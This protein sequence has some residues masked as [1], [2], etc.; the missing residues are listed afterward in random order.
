MRTI[1]GNI[2]SNLET[3]AKAYTDDKLKIARDNAGKLCDG[4]ID[5]CQNIVNAWVRAYTGGQIT[6]EILLENIKDSMINYEKNFNNAKQ[7]WCQQ[8][9]T[10]R[11]ELAKVS[12]APFILSTIHSAKGLEFD[13]VVVVINDDKTM[14]EE[15]KR[16]YYVALT[17]A[18]KSE[19]IIGHTK[20]TLPHIEIAYNS[21]LD[22][23]PD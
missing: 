19:F 15:N 4:W 13:N 23:L 8:K 22:S 10:E 14:S 20:Y 7:Q 9:N 6:H 21:V 17:R 1:S 12:N 5:E 18:I 11:K 2:F 16:M 3:I